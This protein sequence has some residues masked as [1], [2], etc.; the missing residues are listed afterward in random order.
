VVG[1][2][3]GDGVDAATRDHFVDSLSLA[4]AFDKELHCLLECF[5][6][7][8]EQ[9]V[10]IVS[11]EETEPVAEDDS[12]CIL[13]VVHVWQV[14][15]L[16]LQERL[17]IRRNSPLKVSDQVFALGKNIGHHGQDQKASVDNQDRL[18]LEEG[19]MLEL[20]NDGIVVLR[21]LA[22]KCKVDCAAC[23]IGDEGDGA[24]NI[25]AKRLNKFTSLRLGHHGVLL[26]AAIKGEVDVLLGVVLHALG[27]A[28]S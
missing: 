17:H 10:C 26:V 14:V 21:I 2:N 11:K 20:S 24:V 15:W 5:L 9:D 3:D 22:L 25:I 7:L 8:G 6:I 1:N 27:L 28:L 19:F 12:L 16:L 18:A 23:H 4:D 13:E